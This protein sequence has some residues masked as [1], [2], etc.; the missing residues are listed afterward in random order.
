MCVCVCRLALRIRQSRAAIR[1]Q[2][3]Y[4]MYSV[5]RH[6]QRML[7]SAIMIQ[8]YYR[9]WRGIFAHTRY[10]V[11]MRL[12]YTPELS[13]YWLTPSFKDNHDAYVISLLNSLV[14]YGQII[15]DCLLWFTA[16]QLANHLRLVKAAVVFQKSWRGRKG[17]VYSRQRYKHVVM[18]Q[19]RVRMWIA[20]RK[21]KALKVFIHIKRVVLLN[22][23]KYFEW[24]V[25]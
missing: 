10:T 7:Q 20:K 2:S 6:Y 11:I 9:R 18:I 17:R 5:R 15:A 21:L 13:D 12:C 3:M 22:T 16:T 1:I 4:R 14:T 19:C 23:D 8:C 25:Y 24:T